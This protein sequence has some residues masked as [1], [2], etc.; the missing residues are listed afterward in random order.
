[1]RLSALFLCA[2]LATVPL[3]A[4]NNEPGPTT[5]EINLEEG[6]A[7]LADKAREEG[8]VVLESGVM[9]EVVRS[10]PEDGPHPGP[11]DE[12]KVHYEGTLIDGTV[13]DSSYQRGAPA[14]FEVGAV[15]PGWTEALQL[16]TPGD[17]WIV[18]LPADQAYGDRSGGPIP[19]NSVLIFRVE[20]LDYL[21][22]APAFRV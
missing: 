9:Y 15:I 21:P 4:C 1:M 7:W 22:A 13:F 5:A 17:E 19:P 20:L 16:M 3:A 6:E 11:D 10:G 14:I 12:I 18:Y 8:I 2:A